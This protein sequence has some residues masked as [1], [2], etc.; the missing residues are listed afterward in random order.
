MKQNLF[1]IKRNKFFNFFQKKQFLG[2]G[3]VVILIIIS[4][5]VIA[6]VGTSDDDGD[7]GGGS[8]GGGGSGDE[9]SISIDEFLNRAFSQKSF[10][11]SWSENKEILWT[12]QVSFSK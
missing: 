5:V 10:N 7:S 6:T 2:I 8:G 4:I 11:G 3:V 9:S 1:N 12:D